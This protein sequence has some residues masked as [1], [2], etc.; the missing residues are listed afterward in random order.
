MLLLHLHMLIFNRQRL[1]PLQSLDS[2][3]GKL[4]HV[5]KRASF[6]QVLGRGLSF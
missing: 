6:W 2:F 5:H 1:R 3:L 4:V